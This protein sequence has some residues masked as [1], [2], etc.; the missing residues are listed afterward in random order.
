MNVE[1]NGAVYFRNK[2]EE[3]K[4]YP[5]KGMLVAVNCLNNFEHK[6][7]IPNCKRIVASFYFD[8]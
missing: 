6:A 3:F 8:I 7:E 5:K 1:T 2:K 4:V